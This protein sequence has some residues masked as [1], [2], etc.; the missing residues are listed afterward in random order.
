MKIKLKDKGI[1]NTKVIPF[2]NKRIFIIDTK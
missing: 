2:N 1:E